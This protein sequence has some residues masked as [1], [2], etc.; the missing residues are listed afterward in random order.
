MSDCISLEHFK[1][2]FGSVQYPGLTSINFKLLDQNYSL[3]YLHLLRL[4]SSIHQ[5][6]SSGE[7]VIDM[8]EVKAET[9]VNS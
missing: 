1:Q 4:A 7:V 5:S 6:V 9:I 2:V 8:A 3:M